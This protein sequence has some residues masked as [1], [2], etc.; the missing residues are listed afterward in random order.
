M[1]RR[2]HPRDPWAGGRAPSAEEQSDAAG[3]ALFADAPEGAPAVEWHWEEIQA[4]PPG[5]VSLLG[6]ESYPHQAFRL[7]DTAW[8]LQFHPEVLTEAVSAWADHSRDH[9]AAEGRTPTDVA[10]EVRAVE[11]ELR[12]VRRGLAVRW[13]ALASHPGEVADGCRPSG[14]PVGGR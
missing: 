7:G 4:L 3:D 13:A 8:G 9:L 6:T 14:I 10:D 1:P 2:G 12:E 5:A 11:P